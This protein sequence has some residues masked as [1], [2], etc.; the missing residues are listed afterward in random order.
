[1]TSYDFLQDVAY[2]LRHLF[3]KAESIEIKIKTTPEEHKLFSKMVCD[4][5]HGNF[6]NV[7]DPQLQSALDS[8]D[9]IFSKVRFPFFADI[10]VTSQPNAEPKTT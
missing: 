8:K 3:P 6:M 5:S 1:M 2:H 7:L 4:H 9:Y 10:E